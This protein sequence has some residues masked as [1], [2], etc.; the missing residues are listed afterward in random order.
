MVGNNSALTLAYDL[1]RPFGVIVSVGVHQQ[2]PVPFTGRQLYNKNVAFE[3]GRCPVRSMFPMAVDLLLRR[4][5][6]FGGVGS[7]SEA[8]LIDR[9]AGLDEAAECYRAFD[10][11][12]CGKIIFDTWK[13]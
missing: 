13:V 1:I 10:K 6:V 9:V 2:P 7:D 4:Q 5:D 12:E 3:F 8:S 11:G